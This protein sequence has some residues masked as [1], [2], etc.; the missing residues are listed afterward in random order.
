MPLR[1]IDGRR[2]AYIVCTPGTYRPT[3]GGNRLNVNGRGS[4]D[5]RP[6]FPYSR[7]ALGQS[8]TTRTIRRITMVDIPELFRPNLDAIPTEKDHTNSII[9]AVFAGAMLQKA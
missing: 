1:L 6:A 9:A 4:R 5:S 8:K 2:Q 7:E 3:I